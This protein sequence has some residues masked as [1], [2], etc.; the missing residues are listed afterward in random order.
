MAAEEAETPEARKLYERLVQWETVHLNKLEAIYE[1]LRK[2]WWE[3]QQ[4]S[5]A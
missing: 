4:F 3:T 5:P 1:I 2:E